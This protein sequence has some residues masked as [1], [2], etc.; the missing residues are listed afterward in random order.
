MPISGKSMDRSV[1]LYIKDNPDLSKLIP[2]GNGQFIQEEY[3]PGDTL[4]PAIDGAEIGYLSGKLIYRPAFYND[5]AFSLL[6]FDIALGV[7][8]RTDLN[9]FNDGDFMTFTFLD[10]E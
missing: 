7:F 3:A 1:V 8:D 4:M 9:G 6:R 10:Y 2:V 5:T